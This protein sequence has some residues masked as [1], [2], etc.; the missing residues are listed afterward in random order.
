MGNIYDPVGSLRLAQFESERLQA[1]ARR[2]NAEKESAS[3]NVISKL[4]R[5]AVELTEK[6]Q[7]SLVPSDGTAATPVPDVKPATP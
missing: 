6:L 5:E 3:D 7:S 1:E 4:H 2:H